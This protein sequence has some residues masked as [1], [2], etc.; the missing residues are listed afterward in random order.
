MVFDL[1][2]RTVLRDARKHD[3]G[4]VREFGHQR[5]VSAHRFDRLTQRGKQQVA[6]LLQAR[7]AVLGDTQ[8]LAMRTCVSLRAC[9]SSRN[10]ISSAI[11]S[12][13]PKAAPIQPGNPPSPR[14]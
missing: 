1:S 11:S 5:Q 2:A 14:N 6:A 9:R 4:P 10:V 13:A 12:A 7:D 8:F 3:R